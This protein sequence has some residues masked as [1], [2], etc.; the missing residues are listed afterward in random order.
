MQNQ[1]LPFLP[2]LPQMISEFLYICEFTEAWTEWQEHH[3]C[4]C[5][6]LT[7]DS[8]FLFSPTFGTGREWTLHYGWRIT[9]CLEAT[10]KGELSFPR[11]GA[12]VYVHTIKYF[13]SSADL[14]FNKTD[15]CISQEILVKRI[16]LNFVC[17]K[18]FHLRPNL[19]YPTTCFHHQ[20]PV[21]Q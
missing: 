19:E 15:M 14:C 21:E 2:L 16:Q 1:H 20:S 8:S 4:K 6:F 17:L 5:L 7:S 9:L 11:Y 12:S 18:C 13:S 10:G 3:K